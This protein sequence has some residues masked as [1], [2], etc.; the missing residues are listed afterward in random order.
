MMMP[1]GYEIM[2][3]TWFRFNLVNDSE[4][5]SCS[6]QFKHLPLTLGPIVRVSRTATSQNILSIWSWVKTVSHPTV[7]SINYISLQILSYLSVFQAQTCAG[8]HSHKSCWHWY[9]RFSMGLPSFEIVGACCGHFR[10]RA[11]LCPRGTFR[12]HHDSV[13]SWDAPFGINHQPPAWQRSQTGAMS[14][15]DCDLCNPGRFSG[16]VG[17][18]LLVVWTMWSF[19]SLI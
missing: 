19:P 12:R 14:V 4:L 5:K 2:T 16:L 6:W 10:N 13:S 9:T 17:W 15:S 7:K 1:A 11:I 18:W 3:S 8:N